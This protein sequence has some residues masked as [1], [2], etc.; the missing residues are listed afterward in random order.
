[1]HRRRSG[2]SSLSGVATA[3]V[4]LANC[5]LSTSSR[6]YTALRL[7]DFL[8]AYKGH[9]MLTKLFCMLT[10]AMPIKIRSGGGCMVCDMW[11]SVVNWFSS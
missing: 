1:M 3:G 5:L 9:V 4:F 6:D 7:G 10:A 2:N 11:H 8:L